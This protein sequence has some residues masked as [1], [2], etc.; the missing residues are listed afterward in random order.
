MSGAQSGVHWQ[1]CS[2]RTDDPAPKTPQ[3][4]VGFSEGEQRWIRLIMMVHQT[5]SGVF[6]VLHILRTWKLAKNIYS[7]W[8]QA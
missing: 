8:R 5:I 2:Q 4:D 3:I 7:D 1:Y 6:Q